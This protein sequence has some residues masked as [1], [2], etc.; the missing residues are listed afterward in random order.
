MIYLLDTNIV[1][2][3]A[4]PNS[5]FKDSLN[6][7]TS[8]IRNQDLFISSLTEMEL[9]TGLI[10]LDKSTR[11][12]AQ[13]KKVLKENVFSLLGALAVVPFDSE[14]VFH[15]FRIQKVA[16][17]QGRMLSIADAC[18]AGQAICMDAT[19][20]SHDK[21]AFQGLLLEG[22]LWEDWME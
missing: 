2:E 21:K 17:E 10:L 12:S 5:P 16:I 4:T 14:A 15:A 1:S 7:K 6:S 9:R 3:I 8:S 19:L 11:I 20:V 18:I 13:D 22:F